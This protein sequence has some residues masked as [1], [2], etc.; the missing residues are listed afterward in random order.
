MV[1]SLLAQKNRAIIVAVEDEEGR[2]SMSGA[3]DCSLL[4]N[5]VYWHL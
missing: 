4:V 2:N 5:V 1:Y 3:I